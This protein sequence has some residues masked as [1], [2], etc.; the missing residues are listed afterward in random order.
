MN[1]YKEVQRIVTE[2][3]TWVFV[4]QSVLQ[5]PVHRR[6][7]GY[8]LPVIGSPDFWGVDVGD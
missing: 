4:L 2:E 6:V 8:V 7:S 1:L 3:A 5:Q